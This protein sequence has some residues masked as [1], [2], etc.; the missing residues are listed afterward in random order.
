M[1]ADEQQGMKWT[2]S[3]EGVPKTS[4]DVARLRPIQQAPLVQTVEEVRAAITNLTP[5]NLCGMVHPSKQL[6]SQ[7][8]SKQLTRGG[9]HST[10]IIGQYFDGSRWWYDHLQSWWYYYQGGYSRTGNKLDLQFKGSVTRIPEEWLRQ[11]L[12]ERDSYAMVGVQGL[13][14]IDAEYSRLMA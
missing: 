2:N 7:G 3:R 11:W 12:A 8:T 5:I 10:A 14:P 1:R 9:G 13:E 4:E 6:D